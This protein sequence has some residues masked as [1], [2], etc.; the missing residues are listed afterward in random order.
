[1]MSLLREYL[2]GCRNN[3]VSARKTMQ[4]TSGSTLENYCVRN[5]LSDQ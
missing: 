1:M 3:V 5:A 2:F 4:F